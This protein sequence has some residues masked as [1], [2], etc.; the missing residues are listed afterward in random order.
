MGVRGGAKVVGEGSGARNRRSEPPRARAL[1]AQ[2]IRMGSGR[3]PAFQRLPS[4]TLFSILGA[5]LTETPDQTTACT[6][7]LAP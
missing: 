6:L 1:G 7:E 5:R 3:S 2:M 4:C